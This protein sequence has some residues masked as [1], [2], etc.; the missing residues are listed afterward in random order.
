LKKTILKCWSASAIFHRLIPSTIKTRY[1]PEYFIY[2]DM[3]SQVRQVLSDLLSS[4][5]KLNFIT[6]QLVP[7]CDLPN[8]LVNYIRLVTADCDDC[9]EF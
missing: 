3:R 2:V 1:E 9:D 7:G 5:P 4:Y 6:Q 8:V